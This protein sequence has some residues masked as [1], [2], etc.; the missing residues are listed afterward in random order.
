MIMAGGNIQTLFDSV[1]N[2]RVISKGIE[3]FLIDSSV[4][5]PTVTI[6][7]VVELVEILKKRV[8]IGQSITLEGS[9]TILTKDNFW[10]YAKK[11]YTDYVCEN[12]KK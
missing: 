1:M 5:G 2:D 10:E 7:T 3:D 12:V 9:G 4:N 11:N 8:D 6:A